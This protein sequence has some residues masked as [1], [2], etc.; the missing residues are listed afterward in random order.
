MPTPMICFSRGL[1]EALAG[2]L[3]RR[4]PNRQ[5]ILEA[6]AAETYQDTQAELEALGGVVELTAG[7]AHDL[8]LAFGR[9]NEEYLGGMDPPRLTWNRT[10]AGRKFG[11]YDPLRDT[12]MVS[13]TLDRDSVPEFVVDFIMYHE[14]LHKKHGIDWRN[15]QARTH[16]PAFRQ[17]E[18][19]FAQ[20]SEA[21][22]VLKGLAKG[23]NP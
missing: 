21:E 7:M 8:A 14:L 20:F 23:T 19:H 11:H 17:E 22:A 18:R 12:V 16:T 1:F 13:A 9:V 10:F 4:E 2:L 5:V 15:G 6:M 3:L